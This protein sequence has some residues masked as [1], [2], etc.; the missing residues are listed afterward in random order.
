MSK[1]HL[2]HEW[3]KSRSGA[4]DLSGDRPESRT[5]RI[6]ARGFFSQS[7]VMVATGESAWRA[8]TRTPFPVYSDTTNDIDWLRE[9]GQRA[10]CEYDVSAVGPLERANS[11]ASF[12]TAATEGGLDCCCAGHLAAGGCACGVVCVASAIVIRSRRFF[13]H[14]HRRQPRVRTVGDGRRSDNLVED[15]LAARGVAARSRRAALR[16]LRLRPGARS[17]GGLSGVRHCL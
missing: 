6:H 15:A 14:S 8:R 16:P 10:A 5:L 11:S 4:R 12:N 13:A 17:F 7:E 3:I 1:T 2:H 9:R